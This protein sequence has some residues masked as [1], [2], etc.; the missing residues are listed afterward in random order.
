MQETGEARVLHLRPGEK[1]QHKSDNSHLLFPSHVM[2]VAMQP[3]RAWS[4]HSSS[5]IS[6]EDVFILPLCITDSYIISTFK[7]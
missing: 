3:A 6:L 5:L 2:N 4:L 7:S 1:P